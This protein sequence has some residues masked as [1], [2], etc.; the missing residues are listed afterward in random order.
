M[1]FLVFCQNLLLLQLKPVVFCLVHH[2][3]RKWKAPFF[4]AAFYVFKNYYHVC[5]IFSSTDCT[6]PISSIFHRRLY[7]LV[8]W[9]FSHWIIRALWKEKGIKIIVL[10]III[11]KINDSITMHFIWVI[12]NL[13]LPLMLNNVYTDI[14]LWIVPLCY[15]DSQSL[16]DVFQKISTSQIGMLSGLR[17]TAILSFSLCGS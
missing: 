12:A 16:W 6:E 7:F 13:T 5:F 10:V 1:C 14:S 3:C 2:G 8:L 11:I 4:A 17:N 9:S 15:V